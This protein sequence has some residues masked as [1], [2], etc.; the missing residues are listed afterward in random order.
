[1]LYERCLRG[2]AHR[3][4]VSPAWLGLYI[5]S[6][7]SYLASA[8]ASMVWQQCRQPDSAS[9]SRH[10]QV[11]SAA[12]LLAWLD[13]IVTSITQPLH[14][15][16]AKPPQQRRHQ[17]E[18]ATLSQEWLGIYIMPRPSHLVNAVAS[19]THQH[20]HS[21]TQHLHHIMAKLPR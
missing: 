12:P 3:V 16:A 13:S 7:P 10:D 18:S 17:P 19:M 5:V 8:V 20:C 15:A 6:W 2:Y 21:M 14:R 9:T 11:T 4:I 1:M